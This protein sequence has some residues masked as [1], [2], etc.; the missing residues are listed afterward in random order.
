MSR[1]GGEA[2]EGTEAAAPGENHA[3]VP[4]GRSA[5]LQQEGP[6]QVLRLDFQDCTINNLEQQYKIIKKSKPQYKINTFS[7]LKRKA[8]VVSLLYEP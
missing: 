7:F 8:I 2:K 3:L 1:A 6:V 5:E 4:T